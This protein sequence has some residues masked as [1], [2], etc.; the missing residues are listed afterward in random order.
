MFKWLMFS[1][2]VAYCTITTIWPANVTRYGLMTKVI[3]TDRSS[4]ALCISHMTEGPDGLQALPSLQF[5]FFNYNTEQ[6]GR[7]LHDVPVGNCHTIQEI[8]CKIYIHH[9]KTSQTSLI[10]YPKNVYVGHAEVRASSDHFHPP[11]FYPKSQGPKELGRGK[12][13]RIA[14]SK[15]NSKDWE[16]TRDEDVKDEGKKR[17]RKKKAVKWVDRQ[18]MHGVLT[19]T[20]WMHGTGTYFF[21]LVVTIQNFY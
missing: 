21:L 7:R 14:S 17:P 5:Y 2:R 1:R 6:H 13:Q 19:M 4:Y 8:P 10:S 20:A 9:S 12:R 18:R 11:R 15:L 16:Y 3:M